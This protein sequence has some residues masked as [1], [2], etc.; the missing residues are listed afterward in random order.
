MKKALIFPLSVLALVSCNPSSP[1]SSV[2]PSTVS[3]EESSLSSSMPT[4]VVSKLKDLLSKQ[5][6][7]PAKA[8]MFTSQFTQNYEVYSSNRDEE[9]GAET[10]FYSYRGAGM[11]GCLYEVSEDAYRQASSLESPDFFDYM[12]RGTGDYGLVQSATL[13][14]YT[15][16]D[17]ENE[18]IKSLQTLAF[19]QNLDVRFASDNVQVVNSLYTKDTIDGAYDADKGQYFN[20]II[21]K[22]ALFGAITVSA[23]SDIFAR[24]S[25]FDGQRS[26]EVLDRI[27]FE[28]LK[29]LRSKTDAE[30][31]EFITNNAICFEE[32]E[33]N[34]LVH[35]AVG[36]GHLREVLDENEI[37]PGTLQGTLT[38][39]KESGKFSAYEYDIGYLKN[40]SDDASVH[41]ASMEFKATGYS[42]NQKYDREIYIDPEVKVY[43]D[44]ETFLDDVVKEVIPPTL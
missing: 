8:K 4:E 36:D 41:T 33:E 35:F 11:F 28:T 44:A 20:G 9:E 15:Y 26:C 27:Y 10:Q 34:I 25:L 6:L 40:E 17:D 12:A 5:D 29:E 18:A 14:S 3:S 24:T 7:G 38:Y 30:L 43:E 42:W 31:A 2:V 1:E 37:I 39:E 32:G 16:E 13:V 22:A 23:L 19:M 21:D